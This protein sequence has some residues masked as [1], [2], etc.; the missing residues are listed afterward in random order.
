MLEVDLLD[1]IARP[2]RLTWDSIFRQARARTLEDGEVVISPA[3][4]PTRLFYVESGRLR[5]SVVSENGG[6]KAV[7]YYWPGDLCGETLLFERVPVL[8]VTVTSYGRS[9]VRS[10][11]RVEA[12]RLMAMNP[13]L[14]EDLLAS[15]AAKTVQMVDHVRQLRFMTVEE[16]V[17]EFLYGL[18]MH[19][20]RHAGGDGDGEL[21]ITHDEIAEYV[22]A[23]RVSVT[24]ALKRLES[25]GVVQ[26]GRGRI[27][28][29]DPLG[30]RR[31]GRRG[32]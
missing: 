23:H 8:P 28:V 16:R 25:S 10:I 24:E 1:T 15:M 30:L 29:K 7:L 32:A 2:R 11:G 3:E 12:R 17:A 19:M 22:G 20:A 4:R 18:Y 14:A 26:T 13:H 6:A 31:G 21:K 5:C 9:V 27:L